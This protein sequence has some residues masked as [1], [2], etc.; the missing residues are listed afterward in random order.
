MCLCILLFLCVYLSVYV[1]ANDLAIKL[2]ITKKQNSSTPIQQYC[3][4]NKSLG[5]IRSAKLW[6][7]GAECSC[8][9]SLKS[10]TTVRHYCRQPDR[11]TV[12]EAVH[13]RS[14]ANARSD[15]AAIPLLY[16]HRNLPSRMIML[17]LMPRRDVCGNFFGRKNPELTQKKNRTRTNCF[18][19]R[20][21]AV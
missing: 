7:N 9:C 4:H 5:D 18:N 3:F 2:H 21:R 6:R 17:L 11:R 13:S 8:S 20:R 15:G 16:R 10:R 14:G 12:Y 19:C 1:S